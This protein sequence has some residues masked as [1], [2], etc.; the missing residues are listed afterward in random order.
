MAFGSHPEV[1]LYISE[2]HVAG[3]WEHVSICESA[4]IPL[5]MKL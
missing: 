2:Y 4:V 1:T 3:N 5:L